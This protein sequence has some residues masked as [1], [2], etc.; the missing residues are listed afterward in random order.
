VTA[1]LKLLAIDDPRWSAFCR[2]R[3]AA[4]IFHSPAWANLLTATYNLPAQALVLQD[5]CGALVAG[6]P[7]ILIHRAFTPLRIVSL[8]YSDHCAP[9][10]TAPGQEF[11]LVSGLQALYPGAALELRWAYPAFPGGQ[12][13]PMYVLHTIP[14]VGGLDAAAARIHAMHRRNVRAA[15]QRGIDILIDPTESSLQA[16]YRLHWLT[17][18]RQ[19]V[20]VQPLRFFQNLMDTF[21]PAG[22]GFFLLARQQQ[23]CVA[24]ALFLRWNDTLTYKYGASDP[25]FLALR[26]NDLIFW[27]AIRWGCAHGCT[28]LDLGRT[29]LDNTGLRDFKTRW[30]AVESSLSYTCSPIAPAS[31]PGKLR[32]A[33]GKLIRSAPPWVCRAIGE[34]LYRYAA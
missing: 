9:L 2:T 3:E 26:P 18:R 12:S 20:P 11:A 8:P 6:L 7:F 13:H 30:G 14:L 34:A 1:N 27:E 25:A 15:Q 29:D 33:L 10:T 28:S 21:F 23:N 32:H 19:G 17:R 22:Q 4:S 24:A 5:E 31:Q 16:F